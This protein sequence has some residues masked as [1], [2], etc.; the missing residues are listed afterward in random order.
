M[1][2]PCFD[3]LYLPKQENEFV[4]HVL[5]ELET[6]QQKNSHK[7]VLLFPPLPSRLRY[8]IHKTIEDLPELTTFSVGESWCR[9]VVVCPCDMS[10]PLS[11]KGEREVNIKPRPTVPPR[12]R[13]PKRPDK[14]LYMPRAARERLSL[15]NSQ[16]PT[17]GSELSNSACDF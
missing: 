7:S 2:F 17:V 10:Y 15:Q 12:S 4:H 1:A 6:Y 13:A 9:R 5:G 3:G 16:G 8:L 11:V 14:P